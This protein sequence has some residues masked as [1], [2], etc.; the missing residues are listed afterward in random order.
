MIKPS[1]NNT[2][3]N[4]G[5]VFKANVNIVVSPQIEQYFHKYVTMNKDEKRFLRNR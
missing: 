4:L 2:N 5:T 1:M 3:E